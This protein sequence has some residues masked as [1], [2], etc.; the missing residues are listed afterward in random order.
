MKSDALT[1]E[2]GSKYKTKKQI[3]YHSSLNIY[4]TKKQLNKIITSEKSCKR[5]LLNY[6]Q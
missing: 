3:L 1:N 6:W 5:K 2:A 4:I